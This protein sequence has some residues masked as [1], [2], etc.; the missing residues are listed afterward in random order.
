V[1]LPI[2][3]RHASSILKQ[4]WQ[5]SLQEGTLLCAI[6]NAESF[7]GTDV[8]SLQSRVRNIGNKPYLSARKY[9]S[10]NIGEANL[11]F[12]SARDTRLP[13]NKNIQ[14]YVIDAS[15][16]QCIQRDEKNRMGLKT[17][18]TGKCI[19]R[20]M[21]FDESSFLGD[22][23]EIFRQCFDLERLLIG[24]L[25]VATMRRLLQKAKQFFRV[26]PHLKQH[27][28][29]QQRYVH[30]YSALHTYE[31]LLFHVRQKYVAGQPCDA[32]LSLLKKDSVEAAYNATQELI[33]LYGSYGYKEE[34]GAEKD[35]R[36]LF[37]LSMLGGT[38][39]LHANTIFRA[40]AIE[41]HLKT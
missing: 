6:A 34:L 13:T 36:D 7:S 40:F 23:V 1:A 32:E 16:Q 26:K 25:A 12:L 18:A 33:H 41:N 28:Y 17:S 5:H 3:Q 39:E 38:K 20:N 19:I 24:T 21:P 9:S 11:I 27:Q 31:P 15:Q 2:F 35:L 4:K 37:G 10:T 22:G 14:V 30:I 29:V 8:F